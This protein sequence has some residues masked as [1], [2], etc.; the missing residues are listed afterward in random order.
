MFSVMLSVIEFDGI[1]LNS[2]FKYQYKLNTVNVLVK[3]HDTTV[4]Q[5]SRVDDCPQTAS[6]MLFVDTSLIIEVTG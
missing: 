6:Q 3:I 4:S 5:S 2:T 1:P